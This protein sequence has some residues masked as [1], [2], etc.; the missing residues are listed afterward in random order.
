MS[1]DADDDAPDVDIHGPE[2]APDVDPATLD[3]GD[4]VEVF[5]RSRWYRA[6]VRRFPF[7]SIVVK[8][9]GH[10][11]ALGLEQCRVRRRWHA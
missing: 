1:H 9:D 11:L 6:I 5:F 4:P 10:L 2:L 7:A 8:I 3:D